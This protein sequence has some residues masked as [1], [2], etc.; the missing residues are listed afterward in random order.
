MLDQIFKDYEEDLKFYMEKII[1][2]ELPHKKMLSTKYVPVNKMVHSQWRKQCYQHASLEVEKLRKNFWKHKRL[3]CKKCVKYFFKRN[4]QLEFL[5][6]RFEEVKIIEKLK[7][8]NFKTIQ[9]AINAHDFNS[10]SSK[11]FDEFIRI[12]TPLLRTRIN[13]PIKHHKHSNKYKNWTRKKTIFLHKDLQGRYWL[14]LIW[15]KKIPHKQSEDTLGIDMG[16]VNLLVTSRQEYI[17]TKDIHKI[18]DKISKKK[19]GSKNFKQ[20]LIHRNEYI[21]FLI[22]NLSLKDIKEI[23]V[24]DLRELKKRKKCDNKY[25]RWVYNFTHQKLN[26]FCEENGVLFTIV[27]PA[28]TSQECSKCGFRHNENRVSQSLFKC[29]KCGIE[30]EADY[31]ASRNILHKG[32]GV[33]NYS[34]SDMIPLTQKKVCFG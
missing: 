28:Y 8:P 22:N 21:N 25:I 4:R 27:N 12:S 14:K 16:F 13:F 6:K 18:Y 5:E 24:E 20:S 7:V 33:R 10:K 11:H 15:E 34:D 3:R 32:E 30:L 1:S 29:L 31:N 17:G 9:I 2:G 19:Q 26:R 23:K